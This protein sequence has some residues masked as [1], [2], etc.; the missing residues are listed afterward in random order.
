[1]SRASSR[2]KPKSD[3]RAALNAKG[4][5]GV[6]ATKGAGWDSESDSITLGPDRQKNLG[7][8]STG[9]ASLG[10][11]AETSSAKRGGED[12]ADDSYRIKK[13]SKSDPPDSSPSPMAGAENPDPNQAQVD[14]DSSEMAADE[15]S[16]PLRKLLEEHKRQLTTIILSSQRFQEGQQ[17]ILNRVEACVLACQKVSGSVTG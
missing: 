7:R 8:E 12:P 1:M 15:M 6:K 14:Q 16:E 10:Q 11:E 5:I 4:E 9:S 3:Y 17:L 13:K 2:T